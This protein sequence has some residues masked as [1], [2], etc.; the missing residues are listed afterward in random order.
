VRIPRFRKALFKGVA[1]TIEHQG[2]FSYLSFKTVIDIGAHKG[3]FS[4]FSLEMFPSAQVYSFEP[5]SGPR[6]TLGQVLQGEDR[7]QIFPSAIGPTDTNS[8]MNVSARDDSSSLLPIS[9]NQNRIFPGTAAVC[10]EQVDVAP[11]N[12][13]LSAEQLNHPVLLKI[14]V[15]G[16]EREVLDGCKSMLADVEVI[17]IECSFVDLYSGQ[18]LAPEIFETLFGWGYKFQGAYNIAYDSDGQAIQG[19]FLFEKSD[20]TISS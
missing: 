15:Q 2:C 14:D 1:A 19:D 12:K 5:L 8:S 9:E 18:A 11:L 7:I 16:F 20:S 17:Y 4:L 3:Q 10:Q 13:F 6:K